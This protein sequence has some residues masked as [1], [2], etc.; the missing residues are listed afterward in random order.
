MDLQIHLAKECRE[1]RVRPN[2]VEECVALNRHQHLIALVNGPIKP[3]ERCIP[4]S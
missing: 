3:S 1:A 2:R 4:V